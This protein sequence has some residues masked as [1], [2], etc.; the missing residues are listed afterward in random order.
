MILPVKQ[1]TK[2]LPDNLQARSPEAGLRT[3][4]HSSPLAIS[5]QTIID[6]RVVRAVSL[7]ILP[8]TVLTKDEGPENGDNF[9]AQH[10]E[11]EFFK[12][13]WGLGTEQE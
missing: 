2:T 1:T 4:V 6:R 12:N 5:T 8:E 10:T 11:L 3:T 9:Y 13:L 7:H